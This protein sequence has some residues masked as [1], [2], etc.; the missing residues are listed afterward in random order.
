MHPVADLGRK[1]VDLIVFID[2]DGS[3]GGVHDDLAVVALAKVGTYLFNKLRFHLP[4]EVV[5]H[6]AEK[7]GASHYA[8]LSFF[9]RK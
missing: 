2:L 9:C 6:L 4:I 5:G 3:P 1:L 8:V 7:I